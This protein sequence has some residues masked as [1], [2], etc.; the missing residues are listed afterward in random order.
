[1]S[2]SNI[3]FPKWWVALLIFMSAYSP[4][5]IIFALQD[6]CWETKQ[7]AHPKT[8][9]SILVASFICIIVTFRAIKFLEKQAARNVPVIITKVSYYSGELINYSIPYMVSFFVMDLGNPSLLLSF[10]LFMFIMFVITVRTHNTFINPLL[11]FLGYNL[12]KIT[13]KR[14]AHEFED[15]LLAKGDR[16]QQGDHCQLAHLSERL[17]IR[18]HD[19]F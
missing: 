8:T 13:Y 9:F 10:C 12:Y 2:K 6:F 16:P 19:N 14:D 17:T 1:M 15:F 7:L 11:C 3:S 5:S 4:L 18:H